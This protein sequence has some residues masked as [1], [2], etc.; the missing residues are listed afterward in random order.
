VRETGGSVNRRSDET[1]GGTTIEISLRHTTLD[2]ASAVRVVLDDCSSTY[3]GRPTSLDEATARLREGRGPRDAVLAWAEGQEPVAFGHVWRASADEL[4]AFIRCRPSWRGHGA[5]TELLRALED[6]AT[7]IVDRS[8]RSRPTRLTVTNWAADDGAPDFLTRSG[9]SPER[10]FLQMR[11]DLSHTS[12]AKGSLPERTSVRSFREGT[13]DVAIFETFRASFAGHWGD[14]DPDSATWWRENRDD[15]ASGF[16]PTLWFVAEH[17][18]RVCGF[19]IGRDREEKDA[20]VG[21]ISLLGVPPA[22]RARG[23]G[24]A[25]LR[26][27]IECFRERGRRVVALNV[28]VDNVTS[29]LRLYEKV[30]MSRHP[31]FT[32]WSKS[33]ADL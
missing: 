13:D 33:L 8:D 18:G 16:D 14:A 20:T 12:V 11:V 5:S 10:H 19:L 15:P 2:D 27:G 3:V 24:E 9:F 22:W 6:V 32:I 21:W 26:E 7:T 23:I 25:L 29:A 28:D 17:D 31:S 4:R 30:G 1:S